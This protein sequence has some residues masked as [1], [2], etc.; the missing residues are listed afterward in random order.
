MS[1]DLHL[2]RS[3]LTALIEDA[4]ERGARKALA[5]IGL[6]YEDPEHVRKDIT[7]LRDLIDS[8]RG[9]RKG[10]V[11]AVWKAIGTALGASI[12]GF[13]AWWASTNFKH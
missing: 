10:I 4:A 8:W 7:D 11:S 13:M 2:S 9:A 12:L 3:E 5:R 6:D 1:G